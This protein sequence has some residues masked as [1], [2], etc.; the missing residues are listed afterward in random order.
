MNWKFKIKRNMS[1]VPPCLHVL[2]TIN[3]ELKLNLK[4]LSVMLITQQ[5]LKPDD[6]PLNHKI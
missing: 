2:N 1:W 5:R 6:F 4:A 3:C